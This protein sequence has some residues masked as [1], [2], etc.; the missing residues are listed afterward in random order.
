MGGDWSGPWMTDGAGQLAGGMA[1]LYY[2]GPKRA[3]LAAQP[4][5]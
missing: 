5:L 4:G 1:T 2:L 3:L